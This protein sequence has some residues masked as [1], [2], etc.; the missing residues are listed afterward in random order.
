MHSKGSQNVT[1][2]ESTQYSDPYPE[3]SFRVSMYKWTI[4][5]HIRWPALK[6]LI[7]NYSRVVL[8]HMASPMPLSISVC[9]CVC[10]CVCVSVC[11]CVYVCVHTSKQHIST[12]Q[13][14][15]LLFVLAPVKGY[16]RSTQS[17]HTHTHTHTH[18]L[19]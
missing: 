11:M 9:V 4:Y 3:L 16:S 1:L 2:P 17:E 18:T 8:Q 19:S 14:P 6:D 12:K 7:R 10:V 13:M 5:D 15:G